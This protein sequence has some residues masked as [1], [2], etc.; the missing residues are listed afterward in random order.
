MKIHINAIA[1]AMLAATTAHSSS[2]DLYAAM[3]MA[4][5][6]TNTEVLTFTPA[7]AQTNFVTVGTDQLLGVA[8]DDADNLF[9]SDLLSDGTDDTILKITPKG[10]QSTLAS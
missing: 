2:G 10:T 8:F 4:F 5:S 9:V 7:G 6:S 3:Y 1:V